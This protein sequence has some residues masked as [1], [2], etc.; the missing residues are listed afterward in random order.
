MRWVPIRYREFYDIPRLFLAEH[1]GAVYVFDCPFD[2][3]ADEYPEH[4]RVYQLPAEIAAAADAAS[5]EGLAHA[6]TFVGE[7]PVGAV[8]FDA[9]HRTAIDDSVFGVL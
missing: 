8:H 4:Y 2:E 9:T 3:R 6:G 7:V 1:A 5:W